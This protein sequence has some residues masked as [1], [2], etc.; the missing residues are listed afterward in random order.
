MFNLD[1]VV[2]YHLDRAPL[3]QA[4]M[5]VQFPLVAH[6]Q[7]Y[8]GIAP[9]QDALRD[10]FPYMQRQDIQQV[11]ISVGSSGVSHETPAP[12]LVW[13]LSDDAGLRL[14]IAPGAATLS[15][16]SE[17]EGIEDFAARFDRVLQVLGEVEE[18]RRCDRLGVRYVSIASPPPGEET[19]WIQWFRPEFIGWV[20][21]GILAEEARLLSGITQVS[22]VVPPVGP[23]AEAAGD[24]QGLFRHGFV[25]S[26]SVVP[27]VAIEPLST[28]GYVL[29]FDVFIAVP[30]PFEPSSL[31]R[32]LVE[33]H[34]QIDRFFRWTLTDE[35]ADNFGL[36]HEGSAA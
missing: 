32:Q 28:D 2:R 9:V 20:G 29:D 34:S 36:T 35:G 7:T 30:Q 3:A 15:V 10:L 6:L 33:L 8:E 22:V 4:I 1:E 24:V 26:G 14:A 27:G 17:Y 13:E 25:P 16:G 21:G 5:Q 31:M 23:L 18:L 11:S 12:A 19:A